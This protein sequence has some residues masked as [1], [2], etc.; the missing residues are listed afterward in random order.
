MVV[1]TALRSTAEEPA[2]LEITMTR[3]S[4]ASKEFETARLNATI[5]LS[6]ESAG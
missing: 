2:E 4:G 3:A 6:G 1:L 5:V